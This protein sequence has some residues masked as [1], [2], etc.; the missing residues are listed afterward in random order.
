MPYH[1]NLSASSQRRG[2]YANEVH[3]DKRARKANK[4]RW[5]AFDR[6]YQNG[7]TCGRHR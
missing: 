6:L 3:G 4:T 5:D 7:Y 1:E 2:S